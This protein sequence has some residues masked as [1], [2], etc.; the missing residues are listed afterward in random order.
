MSDEPLLA[1]ALIVKDE[2]DKLPGLLESLGD[3]TDEIV[4]YDTGSTD[5]TIEIARAAGATVIEGYW[6][7]DF[8]RARNAGLA[9][10]NAQWVLS[11]DA[12][13]RVVADGRK[14]RRMLERST[15]WDGFFT[16]VDNLTP[17]GGV[18]LVINQMRL[19]RPDRFGWVGAIHEQV[20][21]RAG[22]DGT[23]LTRAERT[24]RVSASIVRIQHIGFVEMDAGAR[25]ERNLR[26]AQGQLDRLVSE[27]SDDVEAL[28]RAALNLGLSLQ[29][30]ERKQEAV[31]AFEVV[32][33]LAPSSNH[34]LI[35]TDNLAWLL[36]H[37]GQVDAV[38]VLAEDL[39]ANGADDRYCDFLVASARSEKGELTAALELLEN[40]DRLV[41]PGG[42]ERSQELITRAID[43]T[44]TTMAHRRAEARDAVID[45]MAGDGTP[46]LASL[47]LSLSADLAPAEL[48]ARLHERGAEHRPAVIDELRTVGGAGSQ[49][50]D[51]LASLPG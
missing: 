27:G 13:D 16:Q 3:W 50:A 17:E 19:F 36:L 6:D 7:D 33:E 14:L 28:S 41:V 10:V 47:L 38:L 4:I 23:P 22:P 37:D 25:V 15:R 26:V 20:E 31:E 12:D 45:A 43:R 34:A 2:Q 29:L 24:N 5:A 46:G 9:H 21:P 49:V 32:R 42:F 48:A 39:R 30:A 44:L 35:A 1:A 51:A 40:I 11:L 18:G 8:G